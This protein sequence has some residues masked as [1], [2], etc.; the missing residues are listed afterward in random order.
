MQLSGYCYVLFQLSNMNTI[1]QIYRSHTF[2]GCDSNLGFEVKR[3]LWCS[4]CSISHWSRQNKFI[5]SHECSF[6]ANAHIHS[7][8]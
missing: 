5:Q 7:F 2:D 8:I 1:D 6:H 4:F 3:V